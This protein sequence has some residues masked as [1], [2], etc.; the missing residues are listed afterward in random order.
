MTRGQRISIPF[1]GINKMPLDDQSIDGLCDSVVNLK[2][3]GQESNPY[4]VPFETIVTLKNESGTTF[5][6]EFGVS[7]ISDAFWQI[8]NYI[9]EYSENPDGSLRRLIVLCQ[10]ESRKCIDIIEPDTWTVVK[11]Q[12]LPQDGNYAISCTRVDEVTVI[13]VSKD[14]KPYLLYYLLDDSFIPQGWPEMPEIVFSTDTASF[15]TPDIEAGSYEGVLRKDVDQYFM[16]TW[17]FRLFDGTT[18]VRHNRFELVTVVSGTTTE[19]VRPIFTLEGYEESI[20]INQPFWSSLIA[21]I[22][23]FATLPVTDKK[24]ALDD[25][26][27]YEVG[28]WPFI[29]KKPE[30]EW[31]TAEDPNII[32]VKSI[33]T[34]WPTGFVISTDNF[35]HHKFSSYVVDSYNKRLLLGGSGVDFAL[36]KI[37]TNAVQNTVPGGLYSDYLTFHSGS[38]GSTYSYYLEDGTPTDFNSP[39]DYEVDELLHISILNPK[40]GRE[41]KVVSIVESIDG[42]EATLTPNGQNLPYTN[43]QANLTTSP[44]K[45][46]LS[47]NAIQSD[48]IGTSLPGQVPKMRIKLEIG[49]I[50]EPTDEVVYMYVQPSGS[51]APYVAFSDVQLETGEVSVSA[52]IYHII[53]IKTD[54]GTYQRILEGDIADTDTEVTLPEVIWY[55]DSRAVKYELI[56]QNGEAFELALS[57]QLNQHPIN[58][59]AY[60]I[61]STEEQ[62]YEIGTSI[63]AATEPDLSVNEVIQ[64]VPSRAQAALSRN[65][66]L[67]DIAATY[68]VGNRERDIIMGFAVNTNPTSEGQAGQ[69][70]VYVLTNKGI[71]AL[72]QTGDPTIAFGRISPVSNFNGVNNPYSFCNAQ[73]LIIAADNKYIYALA[74]LNAQRIDEAISEDP[75]YPNFIKQMRIGY[76]R[77][78]SYEEVIF[79][80]PFYDYSLC[81]NTKYRMWYK[82]TERYKFFFYDYPDLMG[83]TVT[84]ELKNFDTKDE[85]TPVAW[86]IQTRPLI[87][88]EPYMMKRMFY[89][90]IIRMQWK[91][92]LQENAE[93]YSP[94]N[95]KLLGYKDSPNVH[96]TLL[97]QTIKTDLKKDWML[98]QYFGPMYAYRLN[99][100]GTSSHKGSYLH[101]IDA[102]FEKENENERR[103][104]DCSSLFL[105]A[106]D[107]ASISICN[108]EEGGGT[109]AYFP[110]DGSLLNVTS[111]VIT[112]GLN[113]I[114]DAFVTDIYGFQINVTKQLIFLDDNPD[115]PD[116]MR[117]R[118]IF[119][120]PQ[121]F[122]AF[123]G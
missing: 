17:A 37:K 36:P 104:Y 93:D 85:I 7:S 64:Y 62:T 95:I 66:F 28:Y 57:K 84:N 87:F 110:F 3:K 49:P 80:N 82:T 101:N 5:S 106:E 12:A 102:D 109:D 16:V 68:P 89:N 76:H 107:P 71:S 55:P 108:C 9:G 120:E 40:A 59:Y 115:T 94:I 81:F 10:N 112:H 75:D 46:F 32:T 26:K 6:Y 121:P 61:L 83:M 2:P 99:M 20:L 47:I 118:L 43:Y 45:L 18:H 38:G 31:P 41:F 14:K 24:A 111:I 117:M 70:P 122:L 8:R 116:L 4:W 69:Y 52:K 97:D 114:P 90:S 88:K 113:K 74:G 60:S 92:P 72:E 13:A 56:V 96:Y 34:N 58:N 39:W 11:T 44:G 50:G 33:S 100:S 35:T 98:Y 79:S 91:Q 51:L 19:A 15:T 29:D 73:N 21:G 53:T 27:F 86:S 65:P 22:S 54:S 25:G 105:Y 1:L 103:R 48:L 30:A 67:I 42:D 63:V 77:A 23:V 78:A 123:F 119:D